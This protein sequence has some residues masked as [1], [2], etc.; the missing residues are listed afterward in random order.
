MNSAATDP[1][2][3]A[4]LI[5]PPEMECAR[6][7]LMILASKRETVFVEDFAYH[8]CGVGYGVPVQNKATRGLVAL[9]RYCLATDEPIWTSLVV[10]KSGPFKGE[11]N[12]ST[13]VWGANFDWPAMQEEC[14]TWMWRL[15]HRLPGP[16]P[17]PPAKPLRRKPKP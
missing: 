12:Q 15:Q 17:P 14:F 6:H 13:S 8:Y 16:T 10:C 5:L 11:P 7:A 1:V 3:P 9:F 4:D 2:D